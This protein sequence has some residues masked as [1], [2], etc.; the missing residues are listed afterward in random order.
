MQQVFPTLTREALQFVLTVA[1]DYSNNGS[2]GHIDA[3]G[4]AHF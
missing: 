2:W 3:D 1:D 4:V